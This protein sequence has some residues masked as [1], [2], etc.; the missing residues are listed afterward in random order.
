MAPLCREPGL[1]HI[2]HPVVLWAATRR[3]GYA[4]RPLP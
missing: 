4:L 3:Y 1:W 2:S